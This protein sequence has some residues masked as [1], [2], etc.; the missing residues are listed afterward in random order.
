M[1]IEIFE[2]AQQMSESVVNL[3]SSKC[4]ETETKEVRCDK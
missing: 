1:I 2:I 4:C 3:Y